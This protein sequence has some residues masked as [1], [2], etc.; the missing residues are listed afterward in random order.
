MA[1][2]LAALM[3]V[4]TWRLKEVA[5]MVRSEMLKA[6]VCNRIHDRGYAAGRREGAEFVQQQ[7]ADG[8]RGARRFV[9]RPVYRT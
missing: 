6:R 5:R 9:H 2:A 7:Q 3:I 1:S 4:E 8:T